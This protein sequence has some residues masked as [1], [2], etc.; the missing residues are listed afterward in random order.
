MIPDHTGTKLDE[1]AALEARLAKTGTTAEKRAALIELAWYYNPC[2]SRYSLELA[3]EAEAL[4]PGVSD[5]TDSVYPALIRALAMIRMG[6][7]DEGWGLLE[8]ARSSPAIRTDPVLAARVA[9]STLLYHYFRGNRPQALEEIEAL[10]DQ[11][12]W[13]NGHDRAMILNLAGN[14]YS[15]LGNDYPN[16]FRCYVQ[17]LAIARET[18]DLYYSFIVPANIADGYLDMGDVDSALVYLEESQKLV[19]PKAREHCQSGYVYLLATLGKAYR[20]KGDLDKALE[21]I[22]ASQMNEPQEYSVLLHGTALLNLG[23]VYL[24][25]RELPQAMEQFEQLARVGGENNH[26]LL[27]AHACLGI[28]R[29]LLAQGYTAQAIAS[30][31]QA[32]ALSEE[33]GYQLILFQCQREVSNAHQTL[34]D[35][36]KAYRHHQA[37][38]NLWVKVYDAD[39]DRRLKTLEMMYRLEASQREADIA[40]QKSAALQSE[41]EQ[42]QLAQELAQQRLN[43]LEALRTTM[44]DIFTELDLPN[45]LLKVVNRA[46]GLLNAGDGELAL[47]NIEQDNLEVRATVPARPGPGISRIFISPETIHSR[48]AEIRPSVIEDYDAWEFRNPAFPSTPGHS[49]LFAPLLKGDQLFGVL[50][51][52]VDKRLRQFTSD[53]L[54]LLELFAQQVALAIENARLFSGVQFLATTDPLTGI[55]NRRTF[56]ENTRTVLEQMR[57]FREPVALL[58]LDIDTFKNVNDTYGHKVGDRTLETVARYFRSNLRKGDLCGRI[59]GEEFGILLPGTDEDQAIRIAERFRKGIEDLNIHIG[60]KSLSVTVSIGAAAS[61]GEPI[62]LDELFELADHAMYNAKKAGRNRVCGANT[63]AGQASS[64]H[65][66]PTQ[67]DL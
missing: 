51:L 62:Q 60:R 56:F 64:H 33:N 24:E 48:A 30:F 7:T 38:H 21:Y 25:R 37:Y 15:D 6:R 40:R 35:W 2:D 4:Q 55:A 63:A 32:I 18:N 66:S 11:L 20:Q 29:V 9:F 26:P 10:Q 43:E 59:G 41:L 52:G 27:K 50:S 44:Q 5:P 17:S 61:V 1:L 22:R 19:T 47:L 39:A 42:R 49:L 45:L 54:M 53:D 12:Q 23:N 13:L 46:V 14:I 57:R 58:I 28:G 36:E 34:G 67:D 3:G 8:T 16:A 31:E 65:S